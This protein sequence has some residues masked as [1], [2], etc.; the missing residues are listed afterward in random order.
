MVGK[1]D[2]KITLAI[3]AMGGDKA[4]KMVIAG[5]NLAL[6]KYP[7]IHYLIAG[8][9]K[10]LLPFFK[11]YPR[12]RKNSDLIQTSDCIAN[13]EKVS[14]A[15]RHGKN[16][17]MALAIQAVK[18][19]KADGVIS[20][21]NTGVLMAMSKIAVRTIAGIHRPA[22]CTVIP[23]KTGESV[24]LDL[25]ANV[26]CDAENM[27]EFAIMGAL[28]IKC[29]T[30]LKRPTV[31]LLNIGSEDTKGHEKLHQAAKFLKENQDSLPFEFKG[32]IEGDDIG[33]GTTDVVVTD[34]FTGNV[35]LKTIEGTAKLFSH[36]LKE[37]FQS[38]LLSRIAYL[39]L[40]GGM[41]KMR[42]RVDPRRYNGAIFVGLNGIAVKSHGGTDALGF[43]NAI[44]F[45]VDLIKNNFNE[46]I[47]KELENMSHH[48][49]NVKG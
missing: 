39:F 23:T 21:G 42:L 3:D 12:V 13:N 16:S 36:L 47:K 9:E 26:E 24:V 10:K 48:L 40:R 44:E 6:K 15:L 4:P 28:H 31:G 37:M 8:D 18:D 45:A 22:I 38:S 32:F 19:G 17:S 30:G 14:N 33:K 2:Q 5:M 20:S 49:G 7:F 35:A 43:S 1:V 46:K 29:L 11:K 25:G 34:G 41:R 27:I